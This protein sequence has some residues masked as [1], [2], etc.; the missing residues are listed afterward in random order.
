ML[1]VFT[2]IAKMTSSNLRAWQKAEKNAFGMS[3]RI[4]HVDCEVITIIRSE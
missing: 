1:F 2:D 3:V 4:Y